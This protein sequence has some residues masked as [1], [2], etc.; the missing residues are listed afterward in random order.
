MKQSS[1]RVKVDCARDF[2]AAVEPYIQNPNLYK[3]TNCYSYALGIPEA[4]IAVPGHLTNPHGRL[5][6][7]M[8]RADYMRNLFKDD[9][10]IEIDHDDLPNTDTQVIAIV[11]KEYFNGHVLKYHKD[12]TWSYQDGAG[13]AI[14]NL[15]CD[16]KI[17]TDPR[18]ANLGF[19]DEFVAYFKLPK[20]GLAYRPAI[21]V[22]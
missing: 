15:D 22:F 1:I 16:N 7:Y 11:I 9:G 6:N 19:Y 13:Q 2:A 8:A 10:L 17:I 12:G 18:N 4:G 21:S 20:K 3:S 5:Y 14:T